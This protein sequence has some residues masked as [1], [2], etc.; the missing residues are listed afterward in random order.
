MRK[1]KTWKDNA[2]IHRQTK[3][4]WEIK[5]SIELNKNQI[6]TYETSG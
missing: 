2:N 5:Q 3:A 4:T 6:G 1:L